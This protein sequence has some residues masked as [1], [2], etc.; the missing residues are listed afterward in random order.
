MVNIVLFTSKK[1]PHSISPDVA[2]QFQQ[3]IASGRAPPF[4]LRVNANKPLSFIDDFWGYSSWAI[5]CWIRSFVIPEVQANMSD[6][7]SI[8]FSW[9]KFLDNLP[10]KLLLREATKV[11]DVSIHTW[12]LYELRNLSRNE[13]QFAIG[14]SI[15]VTFWWAYCDTKQSVWKAN[16]LFVAFV[17]RNSK[18][19]KTK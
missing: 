7:K 3:N 14:M 19:F 4:L 16:N 5:H 17:S 1:V 11:Q 2:G 13:S 15:N 12:L 9:T 18:I 10:R 8:V 6:G